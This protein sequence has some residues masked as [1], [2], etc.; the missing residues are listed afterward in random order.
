[1]QS[2]YLEFNVSSASLLNSLCYPHIAMTAGYID[3]P[4]SP[5]MGVEVDLELV[6]R[7][8]VM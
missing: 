2:L 8:R 7:Y 4:D 5:G 6:E 1:M 3:V